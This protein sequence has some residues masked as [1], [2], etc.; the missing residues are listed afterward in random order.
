M[1]F[2]GLWDNNICKE[3]FPWKF[4]GS[5]KRKN[6]E[7]PILIKFFS[8]INKLFYMSINVFYKYDK[9]QKKLSQRYKKM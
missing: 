4:G 2:L 5:N 1:L 6:G 9:F 3:E 8:S 7:S